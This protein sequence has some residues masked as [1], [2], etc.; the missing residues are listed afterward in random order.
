MKGPTRN[1]INKGKYHY[2]TYNISGSGT[3]SG[4]ALQP[5][6]SAILSLSAFVLYFSLNEHKVAVIVP[7]ITSSHNNVHNEKKRIIVTL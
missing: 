5:R 6:D 3:L 1:G 7:D 4:L 2:L